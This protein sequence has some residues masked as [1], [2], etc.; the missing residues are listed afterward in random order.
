[1]CLY[2]PTEYLANSICICQ[3]S[4]NLIFAVAVLQVIVC[5]KRSRQEHVIYKPVISI[6]SQL[7]IISEIRPRYFPFEKHLRLSLIVLPFDYIIW[8]TDSVIICGNKMPT[9][10]KR[11][12]LVQILLLAQYVSGTIM[13]IFRS[14]RVLYKWLLPV[15]FGALFFK[16]SVCCGA[17]GYVSGL[18]DAAEAPKPDT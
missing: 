2:C 5:A 7:F 9:R 14:S 15:V 4:K 17:E 18:R 10:C 11:W 13:P 3:R 1:M 12:F 8:P 6:K 16:L